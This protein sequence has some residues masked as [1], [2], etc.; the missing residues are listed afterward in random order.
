MRSRM[1]PDTNLRVGEAADLALFGRWQP[2]VAD[3]G[4]VVGLVSRL[5]T[6]W[7]RRDGKWWR[8][9]EKR[10]HE[11]RPSRTPARTNL[12]C[13]TPV[14]AAFRELGSYPGTC[15]P[16]VHPTHKEAD[17]EV[18]PPGGARAAVGSV[19][20]QLPGRVRARGGPTRRR[21]A[22]ASCLAEPGRA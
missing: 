17:D 13:V 7:R 5:A 12:A 10:A 6:L 11:A 15:D 4:G 21:G 2:R 16:R 8:R 1:W 3:A 9:W 20:R 19:F 22:V 18:T 14:R